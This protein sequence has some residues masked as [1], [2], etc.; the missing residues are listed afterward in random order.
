MRGFSICLLLAGLSSAA[1]VFLNP[2]PP[3]PSRL[4][5]EQASAVIS[6]HLGL[7]IFESLGTSR[8]YHLINEQQFVGKGPKH[9]LLLTIDEAD[10]TGELVIVYELM[11]LAEHP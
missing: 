2:N 6:Q 10:A 7:E 3:L 11:Q 4:S 9:G 1:R 5:Q 8:R